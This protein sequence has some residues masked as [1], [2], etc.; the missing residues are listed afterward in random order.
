MQCQKELFQLPS[1]VT[2]LNCAYMSPLMKQVE[3]AGMRGLAAKRQPYLLKPHDFFEP[4]R[5]LREAF[6]QLIKADTPDRI[7]LIPS[8]SYGMSIVAQNI[9]I[10]QG[11]EILIVGEQFPSNYYCW[12][13]LTRQS[14]ASLRIVPPPEVPHGRGQLWNERILQAIG[15]RTRVVAMPH[16][17]WADGT[18]FDLRAIRQRSREVGA[19]LVVDGTQSV[20]ALPFHLDEFQPDALICAGYKWL[21]GPYALGVAWFG[22]HFDQGVPLE[23]SWMNRAGS[24]NFSALVN[25]QPH[26]QPYARRYEVGESSNFILLPMLLE[27]IRILNEWGPEHVQS[28]CQALSEKPIA[29]LRRLGFHIEDAGY[30]GAHLWGIRLP[31][32]LDVQ[33]LKQQLDQQRIYVSVRGNAIR[34]SPHVYNE[35]HELDKLV[36]CLYDFVKTH[37]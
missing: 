1:D 12:E 20:G 11:E 4:A 13:R 9:P 10:Q 5:Q 21:M 32:G 34:V 6:A 14:Q 27:S 37:A 26:Y 24:E 2:Y 31:T 25:Y 7:C 28:Y 17:H 22:P 16:V 23:E 15:Q 30:R 36:G 18:S 35:T 3:A 8:V 29:T 19:W 33:Q